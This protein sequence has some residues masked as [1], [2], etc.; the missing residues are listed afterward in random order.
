M[1]SDPSNIREP[2]LNPWLALKF[3]GVFFLIKKNTI[4]TDLSGEL[5]MLHPNES[6]PVRVAVVMMFVF[7]FSS[8]NTHA[9]LNIN[10]VDGSYAE[11]NRPGQSNPCKSGSRI[12]GQRHPRESVVDSY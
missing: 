8:P 4:E 9:R 3:P 6:N 2:W 1:Y 10:S 5:E 12:E 11:Q 7:I